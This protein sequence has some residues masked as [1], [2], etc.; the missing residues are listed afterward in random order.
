LNIIGIDPG[1]TGAIGVL[2]PDRQVTLLDMPVL[3]GAVAARELFGVLQGFKPCVAVVERQ[4]AR[5]GQGVTSTFTHGGT[6]HAILAVLACAGIETHVVAPTKWKAALGLP[7]GAENKEKSRELALRLFP[8]TN[9]L[10][11]KKDHNRA[12]SILI[13]EWFSRQRYVAPP[14]PITGD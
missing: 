5:P 13:S 4:S 10:N 2:G 6:Y 14:L 3:N 8:E 11:R 1:L 12:E 7:G 9:G